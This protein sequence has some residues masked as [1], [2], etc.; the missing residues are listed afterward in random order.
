MGRVIR[1][2]VLVIVAYFAITQGLP[3]V[4]DRV[5]GV[6]EDK[7]EGRADPSLEPA[8]YC[9]HLAH[10]AGA[11][12]TREL[13]EVAP[14]PAEHLNWIDA[15]DD[16]EQRIGEAEKA[17]SCPSDACTAATEALGEIRGLV[18]EANRLVQG[19]SRVLPNFSERQ[20]MIDVLLERARVL[21]R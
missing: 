14:P 6:T 11:F 13:R 4:R 7:I 17:C 9:V 3:W 20:E 15:A 19:D 2:V 10:Q 8:G 16:I 5:E 18:A 12:V 21:S 1:L